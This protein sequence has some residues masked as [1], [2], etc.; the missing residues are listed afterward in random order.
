MKYRTLGRTD[1][2]LSAIGLGCMG[3]STSYGPADEQESLATLYAPWIWGSTF[4]TRPM[5]TEM[6]PMKS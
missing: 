6:E 3:M 1:V 2:Q 4:G 5:C